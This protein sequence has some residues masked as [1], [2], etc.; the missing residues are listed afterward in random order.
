MIPLFLLRHGPTQASRQGA[1][2]GSLDLP[3]E[4]AGEALWPAVKAELL[5]LGIEQVLCS[6]LLRA[7]RHAQDLGLPCQ[8]LPGLREQAFGAWDG[9]PWSDI[10]GAEAFF[11]DPV[12][13]APPAGES[14][15]HCA[16]R[17][18]AAFQ[19]GFGE[20]PTLVLAHAGPLRAILARH[21]GMP[22]ERA[23]DLSWQ[24]FGLTRLEW[25]GPERAVLAW[26]NRPLGRS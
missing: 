18:L 22:L 17:A 14:F 21:L 11:Q 25:H 16:D 15:T 7:R 13:T 20:R 3:V 9:R 23:L 6:D 8:V 4:P 5:E 19:A 24:P 2:L 10:T 1:P 26:H 12:G